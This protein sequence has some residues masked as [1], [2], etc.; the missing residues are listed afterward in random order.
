MPIRSK[1]SRKLSLS[2]AAAFFTLCGAALWRIDN[3]RAD[4]EPMLR[5]PDL[6]ENGLIPIT[7]E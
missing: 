3:V 4:D 1:V 2:I 7:A 6:E 5:P